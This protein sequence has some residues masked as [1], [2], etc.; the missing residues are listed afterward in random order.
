MAHP[1]FNPAAPEG[2]GFA[3]SPIGIRRFL[4]SREVYPVSVRSRDGGRRVRAFLARR[5][6]GGNILE[7]WG[8]GERVRVIGTETGAEV[9]LCSIARGEVRYD[10]HPD[11]YAPGEARASAS[12]GTAAAM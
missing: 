8:D 11:Y 1:A 9:V 5:V 4:A 2:K 12:P 3:M 10:P 7:F 6:A